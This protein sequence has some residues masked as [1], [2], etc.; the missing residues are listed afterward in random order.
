[1]RAPFLRLF[2]LPLLG[3]FMLGASCNA[4]QEPPAAAQGQDKAGGKGAELEM[5]AK[6][7]TP[8]LT[9]GERRSW[10]TLVNELLSPCGE[11]VSVAKCVA[12]SRAC[13]SC[14]PAARY[15]SRLVAEGFEKSEVQDMFA[16]RYDPKRVVEIDVSAAPLRGT[17]MAG[18]TIVEFSD[19][20]CPHCRAAQPLL[21]GI[22]EQFQGKVKLA[23]KHFPLE[24]HTNAVPAAR[25]TYAA[26]QQGKFWE[27]ADAI[28]E[29]QND[30]DETKIRALARQAG[31]DMDRFEADF[32]SEASRERVERD[33][34][35]GDALKIEGTPALYINKRPFN[36]PLPNLEKYLKEEL[37]G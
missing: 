27:L 14:V 8:D 32:T 9:V 31:L 30:L 20:E 33:R 11:P 34:K 2:V 22:V 25:A 12:E 21:A 18:I 24:G 10:V 19:F 17:P 36:E 7:E 6:F 15:V 4:G 3:L 1:M 35:D 26:Q 5:L 23:F 37:G 16:D 13:R 28:F 29:H